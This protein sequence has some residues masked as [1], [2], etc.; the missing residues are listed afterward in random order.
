MWRRSHPY[1]KPLR[2]ICREGSFKRWVML[3]SVV[4]TAMLTSFT[5]RNTQNKYIKNYCF[6]F[7]FGPPWGSCSVT[8]TAVTGHL[9][10]TDFASGY[11]NWS[12]PPPVTLFGAPINTFVSSVRIGDSHVFIRH[13]TEYL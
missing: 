1:P 12:Y 11:K 8:M 13:V 9:T 2:A 10:S 4:T 7:D 5:Q 6:D 3:A